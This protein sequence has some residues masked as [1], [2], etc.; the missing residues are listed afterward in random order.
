MKN[1][2]YL[3][4]FASFMTISACNGYA[5][6]S[7]S[8]RDREGLLEYVKVELPS[9][10]APLVQKTPY[11]HE[12]NGVVQANMPA[13]L[14]AINQTYLQKKYG[15][16]LGDLDLAREGWEQRVFHGKSGGVFADTPG[17]VLYNEAKGIVQVVFRG[18]ASFS[19]WITNFNILKGNVPEFGSEKAQYHSGFAHKYLQSR[20]SLHSVLDGF[21]EELSPEQK[22][23]LSFIVTGHSLGGG[24][25]QAAILDLAQNYG[26]KVFG[27]NFNNLQDP[28]FFGVALSAPR[29][30][31]NDEAYDYFGRVVGHDNVIRYSDANDPV[32]NAVPGKTIGGFIRG[33]PLVGEYLA[34]NFAGYRSTGTL[35]HQ[36]TGRSIWEGFKAGVRGV[37]RNLAEGNILGAFSLGVQTVVTGLVGPLHFGSVAEDTG[38]AFDPQIVSTDLN[39]GLRKGLVHT[40]AKEAKELAAKELAAKEAAKEKAPT[41]ESLA[42][43]AF[44]GAKTISSSVLNGVKSV[45]S[46]VW[47]GFKSLWS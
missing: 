46:N 44:N 10:N 4:A 3:F 37:R 34:D 29:T 41:K 45:A 24:L 31:G 35:A 13:I 23:H 40:K 28:H 2:F 11:G 43:T 5:D 20:E 27:P 36:S 30:L 22:N 17:M 26:K 19:D 9:R 32:T 16:Q 38:G 6:S 47:N 8:L 15:P 12:V 1:K 21:L 25:A 7:V 18:S 39:E 33:I 42:S 14:K